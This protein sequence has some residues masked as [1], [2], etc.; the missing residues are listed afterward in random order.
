[1]INELYGDL[2]TGFK[3]S[4]ISKVYDTISLFNP[5]IKINIKE[6]LK[7]IRVSPGDRLII[8]KTIEKDKSVG[9]GTRPQYIFLPF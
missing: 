4:V 1:M 2:K 5:N 6:L 3:D 7:S 9:S 8:P